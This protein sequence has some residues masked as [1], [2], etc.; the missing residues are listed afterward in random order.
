VVATNEVIKELISQA[1]DKH[2]LQYPHEKLGGTLLDG[3]CEQKKKTAKYNRQQADLPRSR[4][5]KKG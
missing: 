5:T 3:T 4:R 2:D 1:Q